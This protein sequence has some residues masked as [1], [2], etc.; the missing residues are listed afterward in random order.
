MFFFQIARETI[1]LYL[2]IIYMTKLYSHVSKSHLEIKKLKKI[3][4]F[5]K[6]KIKN[7]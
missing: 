6:L 3:K 1:L 5:E 4:K 7:F 2:L